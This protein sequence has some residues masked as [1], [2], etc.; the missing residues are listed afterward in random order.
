M[1]TEEWLERRSL[2]ETTRLRLMRLDRVLE[3]RVGTPNHRLAYLRDKLAMKAQIRRLQE[4]GKV[5]V[6]ESGRDCDG[7]PGVGGQAI[8]RLG[9][10]DDQA[11]GGQNL[12]SVRVGRA[13]PRCA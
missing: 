10:Q 5:A 7:V 6:V 2:P 12:D 13:Q 1:N 4:G 9:R 11:A 8:D 3:A